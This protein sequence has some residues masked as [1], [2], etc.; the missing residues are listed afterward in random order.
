MV[1]ILGSYLGLYRDYVGIMEKIDTTIMVLCRD[2]GLGLG[3]YGN[4]RKQHGN[5][6]LGFRVYGS[7]FFRS[8]GKEQR[9]Y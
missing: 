2:Q 7:R 1:V 8:N 9:N 5:Y 6:Y 3:I 4:D